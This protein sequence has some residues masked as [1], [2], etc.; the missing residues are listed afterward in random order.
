MNI[1][2]FVVPVAGLGMAGALYEQAAAPVRANHEFVKL[3]T[4]ELHARG[5]PTWDSKKTCECLAE[6]AGKDLAAARADGGPEPD[7]ADFER[8]LSDCA[9]ANGLE[10]RMHSSPGFG[11][12]L[13]GSGAAGFTAEQIDT[14][15]QTPDTGKA[16]DW[17]PATRAY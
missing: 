8:T 7:L 13:G 11:E 10:A 4:R 17:G 5:F 12:E 1:W 9:A 3:C 6:D 15:G 16:S 14:W 2:Y